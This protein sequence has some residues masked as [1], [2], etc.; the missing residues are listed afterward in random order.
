M[1]QTTTA[2]PTDLS[3]E[4][5][6]W[7]NTEKADAN[8]HQMRIFRATILIVFGTALFLLKL[9]PNWLFDMLGMAELISN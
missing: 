7:L 8:S 3:P 9:Q 5:T 4:F 2:T 6:E 1:E